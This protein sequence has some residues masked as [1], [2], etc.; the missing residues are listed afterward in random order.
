MYTLPIS[1]NPKT[2]VGAFFFFRERLHKVQRGRIML[3]MEVNECPTTKKAQPLKRIKYIKCLHKMRAYI[4]GRNVMKGKNSARHFMA[5]SVLV[6][7]W[8]HSMFTP[9]NQKNG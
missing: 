6:G 8:K 3:P 7:L 5:F 4:Q 2:V 1:H 9:G